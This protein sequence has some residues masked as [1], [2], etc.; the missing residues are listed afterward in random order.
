MK[1]YIFR[2]ETQK[3]DDGRWS[4]LVPFLPGCSSWGYSE[5]EALRNIQ[6]AVQCHL[7]AIIEDGGSIPEDKLGEVQVFSSPVA[8]ANIYNEEA[9]VLGGSNPGIAKML[10]KD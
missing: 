7:E 4:V 3:E 1:S 8:V 2:V 10:T 9:A 6:V 5:D